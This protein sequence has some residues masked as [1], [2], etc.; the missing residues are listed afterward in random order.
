MLWFKRS[1][2]NRQE[3]IDE[4][5]RLEVVVSKAVT[6]NKKLTKE[7]TEKVQMAARNVQDLV[8]E[9]G[10]TFAIHAAIGGKH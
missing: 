8:N 5:D 2:E 1:R 7:K 4:I 3:Q 9:N 6:S 10:F